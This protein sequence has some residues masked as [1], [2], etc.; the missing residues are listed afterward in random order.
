MHIDNHPLISRNQIETLFIESS[1]VDMPGVMLA[2][3]R[4]RGEW[5][6]PDFGPE[7]LQAIRRLFTD[8]A[9]MQKDASRPMMPGE[10]IYLDEHVISNRGCRT[11]RIADAEKALLADAWQQDG[12]GGDDLRTTRP[13]ASELR[14]AGYFTWELSACLRGVVGEHSQ[15]IHPHDWDRRST[16]HEPGHPAIDNLLASRGYN[17]N[18]SILS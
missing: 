12:S 15:A 1:M 2:C 14:S 17:K 11:Y 7:A 18:G 4:V 3:I 6:L 10:V 9:A 13:L 8:V 5:D 16:V